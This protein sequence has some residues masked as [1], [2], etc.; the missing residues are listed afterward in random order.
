MIS[1]L[2]KDSYYCIKQECKTIKKN[3]K[4]VISSEAENIIIDSLE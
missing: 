4:Y 2:K 1:N 3:E